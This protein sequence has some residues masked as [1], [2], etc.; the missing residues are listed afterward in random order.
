MKIEK[1]YCTSNEYS[2]HG[3]NYEKT[4][5]YIVSTGGYIIEAGVFRQYL[6]ECYVKTVVELPVTIGCKSGCLFCASSGMKFGKKLTEDDIFELF[7][8]LCEHEN[9]SDDR[10]LVSFTGIG[11]FSFNHDN[12]INAILKISEVYP[13][14][15]ITISSCFWTEKLLEQV[16]R[17]AD[18]VR[19]RK[20]QVTY[21]SGKPEI[22]S[23]L[24]PILKQNENWNIENVFDYIRNSEKCYY[25]I[26]YVMIRE[27]NDGTEEF[28]EFMNKI[29]DI[30]DKIIVRISRLNETGMSRA[31]NLYPPEV[32][33]MEKL[34]SVLNKQGAEAYLFF[35][36]RN[37]N[38][39]CGQ[40][41]CEG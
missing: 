11:D 18:R 38:M 28:Q 9:L 41:V 3:W 19:I 26:N 31:S 30:K 22:R 40:L 4:K 16:E 37:D 17:L 24:I 32:E 23:K 2:G 15:E 27:M 39:N 1:I 21:V 12:V 36:V 34:K 33:K 10:V 13:R 7:K 29:G 25:R 8:L 6:N 20:I 5:K 14:V 35:A